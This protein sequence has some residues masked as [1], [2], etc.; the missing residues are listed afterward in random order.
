MP[1]KRGF[2]RTDKKKG[3]KELTTSKVA[4]FLNT[5]VAHQLINNVILFF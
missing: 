5:T 1:G 2:I 4:D 3:Q